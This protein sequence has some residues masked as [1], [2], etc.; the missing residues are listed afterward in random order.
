MKDTHQFFAM[1][2]KFNVTRL[3]ALDAVGSD[4][5]QKVSNDVV[6]TMLQAVV[7]RDI[8]FM[9]F[10]GNHGLIQIH[11][12]PIKKLLRTGQWFNVLDPHFNL[13][14]DTPVI[15]STWIVKK[16]TSQGWATSISC[17][18]KDG[19]LIA[20]FFAERPHAQPP[21]TTWRAPRVYYCTITLSAYS[22]NIR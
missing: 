13:H 21:L 20:P 8:S 15:E 9:C 11:S 17:Y 16:P 7:D 14:L 6:E 2:R 22:M 4:L 5:A 18:T 3:A 10:V 12:G 19:K 1:L